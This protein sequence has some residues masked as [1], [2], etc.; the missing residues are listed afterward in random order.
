MHPGL[1]VCWVIYIQ[2]KYSNK[3]NLPFW[4]SNLYYIVIFMW[5]PHNHWTKKAWGGCVCFFF[6]FFFH[7]FF[8][9]LFLFPLPPPATLSLSLSLSL[10]LHSHSSCH[11]F[12]S[13]TNYFTQ[14]DLLQVS[15]Y[16]YPQCTTFSCNFLPSW[17]GL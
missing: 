3:L 4:T 5:L 11:L 6:L 2:Q 13:L 12:S 8:L 1:N 17:L 10:F 9:P 7:F 16:L 14:N 15:F